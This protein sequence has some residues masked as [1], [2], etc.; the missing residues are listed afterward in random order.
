MLKLKEHYSQFYNFE[1]TWFVFGR[2]FPLQDTTI[3]TRKDHHCNGIGKTIKIYAFRH[4]CTSLLINNGATISLVA[5]Y[6]GHS[7]ISTTLNT[8]THMFK[9]QFDDILEMIDKLD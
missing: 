5:K 9:N 8:Y 4:S 3:Q 7:K 1:L 6:L 2:I